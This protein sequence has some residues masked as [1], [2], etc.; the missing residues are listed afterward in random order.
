VK[1]RHDL[2]VRERDRRGVRIYR[3]FDLSP[4]STVTLSRLR[5]F[6]RRVKILSRNRSAFL[7]LVSITERVDGLS[8]M[9]EKVQ[10]TRGVISIDV[11]I[12]KILSDR[13]ADSRE[14]ANLSR[15]GSPHKFVRTTDFTA[16]S[17]SREV[18]IA[19]TR[20][21]RWTNMVPKVTRGELRIL[22]GDYRVLSLS[23]S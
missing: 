2:A 10:A 11:T 7:M 22:E 3:K 16:A 14:I 23:T 6:V 9:P 17:T 18:E 15:G 4:P 21:L 13:A 5:A 8:S 19:Q 20:R 12:V 1:G